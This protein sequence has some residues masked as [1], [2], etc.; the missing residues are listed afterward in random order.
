MNARTAASDGSLGAT[1]SGCYPSPYLSCAAL[2]LN[3][4]TKKALYFEQA[5][6]TL[7]Q[8][9]VGAIFCSYCMLWDFI[10]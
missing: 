3:P 2:I 10:G 9:N 8:I 7:I 5:R 6:S 4:I 1:K